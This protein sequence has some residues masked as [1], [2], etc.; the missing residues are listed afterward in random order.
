[1]KPSELIGAAL[2]WAVAECEGKNNILPTIDHWLRKNY[3]PS[4]DWAQGGPIIERECIQA[5][6]DDC[7]SGW[8]A[9]AYRDSSIDRASAYD[10]GATLLI[11]AMRCYVASKLG[12][13]IEIPQTLCES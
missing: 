5:W 8:L 1:M 10:T 12:H 11:A 6:K 2:D 13:D 9:S 4:S 7:A 3:T